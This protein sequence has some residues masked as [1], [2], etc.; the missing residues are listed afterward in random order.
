MPLEFITV[1]LLSKIPPLLCMWINLAVCQ[2]F[3]RI[4]KL[5]SCHLYCYTASMGCFLTVLKKHQLCFLSKS[6]NI[7]LSDNSIYGSCY[8][9]VVYA[10]VVDDSVLCWLGPQG[11]IQLHF[12]ASWEICGPGAFCCHNTVAW[13]PGH[14]HGAGTVAKHHGGNRKLPW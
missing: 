12:K 5:N 8:S 2:F 11:G 7:W 14:C 1:L 13:L 4:T 6:P 10:D 9:V 3:I